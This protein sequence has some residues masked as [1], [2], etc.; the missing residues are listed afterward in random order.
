MRS[1]VS[2]LGRF[3]T[4]RLRPGLYRAP[5]LR[6][7]IWHNVAMS[8][9]ARRR[10]PSALAHGGRQRARRPTS[11][12]CP[13]PGPHFALTF[14]AHAEAQGAAE[15]LALLRARGVRATI[16]VTGRFAQRFP[17]IVA[18]A[19]RDGH[20]IGNH[21]LLPPAPD[22]L[23]SKPAPPDAAGVTREFA[24]A[25]AAREPRRRSH[26]AIGRRRRRCGGH[27]TASTTPRSAAGRPS[28]A[29]PTSTGR[30]PTAAPRRPRL[31]REPGPATTS[32]PRRWP[33]A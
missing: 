15:L 31:G 14:D 25:R 5:R 29:S 30:A 9:L 32:A 19:S 6:T 7:A 12:R 4:G 8:A 2:E 26:A 16:F 28:S 11:C 17:G 22:D 1:K 3:H 10:P 18:E 21:T 23:G 27:R 24:A 20:E 33:A 13:A